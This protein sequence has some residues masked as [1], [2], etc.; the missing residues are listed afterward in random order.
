MP[1]D[2]YEAVK[3][4]IK[5]SN[6]GVYCPETNTLVSVKKARRQDRKRPVSE[7]LLMM[8]R[9]YARDVAKYK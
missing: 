5:Y 4:K 2:V 7:M 6:A 3:D 1:K 8:F 9:S